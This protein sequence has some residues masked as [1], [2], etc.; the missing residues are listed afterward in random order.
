MSPSL[1]KTNKAAAR[2]E[3]AWRFGAAG[4]DLKK[5]FVPVE[6]RRVGRPM[7][8]KCSLIIIDEAGAKLLLV[9]VF[10]GQGVVVVLP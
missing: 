7:G 6:T 5:G 2:A 3:R 10:C 8:M 4:W 9:Q 1:T